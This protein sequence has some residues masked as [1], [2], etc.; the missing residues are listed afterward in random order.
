MSQYLQDQGCNQDTH[1]E[2]YQD[3]RPLI[4]V[5]LNICHSEIV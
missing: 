5:K 1:Q 4:L 3:N 2:D